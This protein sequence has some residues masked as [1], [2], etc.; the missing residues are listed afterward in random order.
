M[1]N[2]D[3]IKVFKSSKEFP[4]EFNKHLTCLWPFMQGIDSYT[5]ALCVHDIHVCHETGV[6]PKDSII[7]EMVRWLN[8]FN[9]SYQKM[10]Y[11]TKLTLI[12]D[13]VIEEAARSFVNSVFETY[14]KGMINNETK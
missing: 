11:S 14:N 10:N 5:L 1:M 9:E 6:Y 13:A 2:N 7:H 4:S 3:S 8:D 12:E